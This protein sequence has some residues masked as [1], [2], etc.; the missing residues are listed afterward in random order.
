[1]ENNEDIIGRFFIL[2]GLYKLEKEIPTKCGKYK[3]R[4]QK[5]CRMHSI[6]VNNV[7]GGTTAKAKLLDTHLI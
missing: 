6:E 3:I 2:A 1:M 7:E 5:A 4:K